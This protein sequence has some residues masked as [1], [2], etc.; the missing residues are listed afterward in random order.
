MARRA[1]V[2]LRT[3]L[4]L[5]TVVMVAIAVVSSAWYGLTTL[6][7]FARASGEARRKD[8]EQAIQREAELLTRNA[9]ASAGSLL[10]TSDYTRL[11]ET[12]RR[13]AAENRNVVWIALVE[14]SGAVAAA[15]EAS[16][17]KQGGRFQDPLAE[18][19]NASKAGAV[20]SQPD[21]G[22][23]ERL[24]PGA[25]VFLL[26]RAGTGLRGGEQC[27]AGQRDRGGAGGRPTTGKRRERARAAAPGGI[28][29]TPGGGGRTAA[30][31]AS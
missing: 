1:G 22:G 29:A 3:K 30:A 8:L 18:R 4:V 12:A 27:V 7:E 11:E 2:S 14:P 17:V 21:P 13:L 28:A 19:I 10:A 20:E 15:S 16:P 25:P 5:G 26:D 31:R 6:D 24:L 23:A 9:A